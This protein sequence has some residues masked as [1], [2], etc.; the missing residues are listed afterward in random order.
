MEAL[1]SISTTANLVKNMEESGKGQATVDSVS[2]KLDLAFLIE[3]NSL[4]E[5]KFL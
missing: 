3:M 2:L 1:K 5:P 4:S